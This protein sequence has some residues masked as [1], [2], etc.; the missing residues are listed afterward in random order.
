MDDPTGEKLDAQIR[1]MEQKIT[2]DILPELKTIAAE[3]DTLRADCKKL[4]VVNDELRERVKELVG[5]CIANE[6]T[7]AE[8][9]GIGKRLGIT[10]SKPTTCGECAWWCVLDKEGDD[11]GFCRRHPWNIE[12]EARI[13][14]RIPACP[15]GVRKER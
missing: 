9:I 15:D 4:D 7:I 5:Q 1:A 11:Y 10:P 14:C 3:R 12:N 6:N 2:T 13:L 8:Q